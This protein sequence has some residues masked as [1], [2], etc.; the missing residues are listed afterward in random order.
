M[1]LAAELEEE[2]DNVSNDD[3]LQDD[4]EDTGELCVEKDLYEL[5]TDADKD[6]IDQI[7]QE[8]QEQHALSNIECKEGCCALT[9]VLQAPN[10]SHFIA[11]LIVIL[12]IILVACQ[13][14]EADISLPQSL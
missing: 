14:G 3:K 6:D 13:T 2:E 10:N 11:K 4:A 12:T 8:V 7:I 9:K 1:D 5:N